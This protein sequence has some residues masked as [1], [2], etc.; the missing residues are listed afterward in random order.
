MTA[1]YALFLEIGGYL[2]ANTT[3]ERTNTTRGNKSTTTIIVFTV[4]GVFLGLVLCILVP[5]TV[6]CGVRLKL[7][8][9]S[10]PSANAGT[11]TNPLYDGKWTSTPC[12]RIRMKLLEDFMGRLIIFMTRFFNHVLLF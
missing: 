9:S 7:A 3:E 10:P 5:L 2:L 12:I 6:T 8:S 4:L 11:L 1:V